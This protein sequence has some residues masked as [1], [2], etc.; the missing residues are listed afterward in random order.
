MKKDEKF[1]DIPYQRMDSEEIQRKIDDFAEQIA[2]A[3]DYETVKRVLMEHQELQKEVG[4][5]QTLAMIRMYQDST[6]KYYEEEFVEQSRQEA[7][8]DSKKLNQAL[9]SSKFAENINQEF[10]PEFLRGLDRDN[11]LFAEGKEL[12]AREQELTARYQ[13]LKAGLRFEFQGKSLSEGELRPYRENTDRNVR[14]ACIQAMYQGYLAKREEFAEIL[15]ELIKLRREIAKANGFDSYL[16][17]MNLEK[18][19][20]EYGERELAAFRRQIKEEALPLRKVLVQRQKERLGLENLTIYDNTLVFPDGNPKPAG[21]LKKLYEAARTMYHGLGEEIGRFYDDMLDHELLDAEFSRNKITGLGFCTSLNRTGVP[22][23]F[24]NSNGTMADV[25]VLTHEVG[26]AYQAYCSMKKQP[27]TEYYWMANDLVEI[28]SKTMELFAYPYAEEF[29]GADAEKF[30]FMHRHDIIEDMLFYTMTDEYEGWLY[31]H[32][33]AS[34]EERCET[35]NKKFQEFHPDVDISEFAEEIRQGAMMFSNMGIF[36]FPK[37]LISY[38]LSEMCALEFQ[39]RMEQDP[40]QAWEDYQK[41]CETGASLG[42]GQLMKQSHLHPAYEE[43]AAA[44]A[45][46]GIKEWL[47]EEVR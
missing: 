8:R 20:R 38:V 14:R 30:L 9:I 1:R 21:D 10:G 24:A 11:K 26:H 18:G 16:D 4:E 35:Y 7:L 2:Q 41:F 33:E 6:D 44:R 25:S 40:G 13:Q 39:E 22:F 5:N 43:G 34:L 36:M 28:P 17:Y 19:R 3:E 31:E 47:L 45:L 37:Y 29:F 23:V 27:L 42:Y 46:K 15:D 12:Q 32:P